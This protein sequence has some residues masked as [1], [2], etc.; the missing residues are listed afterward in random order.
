[1]PY[2]RNMEVRPQ[3]A[4]RA[5]TQLAAGI[6]IGTTA[7]KGVLVDEDG[8][9]A[10]RA[11]L[12]S[13][14]SVGPGDRLEHDALATWWEGPRAVLDELF[15]DAERPPVQAVGR[16]RAVAVSAMMP[17]VAPVSK[18]GRPA[19]P[20][21]LY[22]S[23]G[24]AGTGDPTSSDEMERLAALCAAS[25]AGA[26]GYWPAQAVAN[27][28][29]AG[30]GVVDLASA[31]ASGPLFKGSGWD[32]AALGRLGL[33]PARMPRVVVFGEPVGEL[34]RKLSPAGS[35]GAGRQGSS[36]G[37]LRGGTA[38]RGPTGGP[39]SSARRSAGP[40]KGRTGLGAL[41]GAI[42]G[43]GSVD[44]L[45][46]QLVA[47]TS[48]PGDVLI[49]LGSTLV[50][51]LC[52]PGWPEH[53]PPGLWRVPHIAPGMAM[54]GGASNAGG[55]WVDWVDRLLRPDGLVEVGAHSA[56]SGL[57]PGVTGRSAPAAAGR[58]AAARAGDV[59]PAEVPIWW[60]WPR[61][62]RVPWHDGSLRVGLAGAHLSHGPANL[63]RAALE[64]SA[65]V[66][67]FVLEKAATC[68]T[69]ARRYF[70]SGGGVA[71]RAWLQAL[72]EVL[73]QPVVPM[74]APDGAALGAAFLA[75][76]AAGLET[77]VHDAGRWARWAPP[78]EPRWDWSE[79][80]GE[81]FQRWAEGLPA[82]R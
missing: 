22:G 64:A 47:G 20:G 27:A 79:A 82:G 32:E 12:P 56:V 5:G 61:G 66:V 24:P 7:V 76:M 16:L 70:V 51:W 78:V 52:A 44:G 62:E 23:A 50:V 43:A 2:W 11:R 34:C 74:A 14:L 60:P 46:E 38:A 58:S 25:C 3:S 48:Q 72:A 67:R 13:T 65:F 71:N 8:V 4:R 42:L 33:E 49:T 55:L 63:R 57:P 18:G 81:R 68:G 75:R 53:V 29:L 39:A 35:G 41:E 1:L 73:G 6:D 15:C 69:P 36:E 9:V 54:V 28:S 10:R 21:L 59:H 17:S 37:E 30:A 31:F 19:G 45:C 40:P 26:Y 80:A 77:S